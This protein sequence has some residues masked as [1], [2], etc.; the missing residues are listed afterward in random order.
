MKLLRFLM[1]AADELENDRDRSS[2]FFL[3][4]SCLGKCETSVN[5]AVAFS[6]KTTHKCLSVI[7]CI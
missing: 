5:F 2:F 4:V 1:K 3:Y 7:F 6:L